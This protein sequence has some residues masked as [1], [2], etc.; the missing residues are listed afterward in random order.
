M[1]KFHM[2]LRDAKDKADDEFTYNS[3]GE[4]DDYYCNGGD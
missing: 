4:F 3:V 2:S 1:K